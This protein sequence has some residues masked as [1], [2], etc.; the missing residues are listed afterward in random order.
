VKRKFVY[1]FNEHKNPANCFYTTNAIKIGIKSK[2]IYITLSQKRRLI[3]YTK[4]PFDIKYITN[5]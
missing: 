2:N 1:L 4:T 3:I 5:Y